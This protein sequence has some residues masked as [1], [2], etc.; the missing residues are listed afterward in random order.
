[1]HCTHRATKKTMKAANTRANVAHTSLRKSDFSGAMRKYETSIDILTVEEASTN[2]VWPARDA[3][4]PC[5]MVAGLKSHTCLSQPYS[6]DARITKTVVPRFE[7]TKSVYVSHAVRTW[8]FLTYREDLLG[9]STATLSAFPTCH[10]IHV[11]SPTPLCSHPTSSSST[12]R[13]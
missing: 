2:R 6:W 13:S 4:R 12:I 10:S 11:P 7:C 8:T 5:S 9:V 1:M 3:C